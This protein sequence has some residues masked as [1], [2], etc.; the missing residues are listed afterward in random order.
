MDLLCWSMALVHAAFVSK[1]IKIFINEMWV[2]GFNKK[3]FG[4]S[5][6]FWDLENS[7]KGNWSMRMNGKFPIVFQL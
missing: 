6:S 2:F 5:M 3:L 4:L 7:T 1:H